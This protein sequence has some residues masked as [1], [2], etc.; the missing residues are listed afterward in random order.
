MLV[1]SNRENQVTL[2]RSTPMMAMTVVLTLVGWFASSP[3]SF[4]QS[5]KESE[6]K[7]AAD[8]VRVMSFNIRFGLA[9]DGN[10]SWPNRDRLV[11]DTINESYPDLL[12]V[13][14]AMPFQIQFL[15]ENLKDRSYVGSSR[16]ANP[17]GEQCGVFYRTSRFALLDQGQFWL[18]ETPN[19]KFT[20]S[21]DSSLPR[22]ATW[23]RL[24]DLKTSHQL[25][26]LNTHFD[27]RG[28]EARFQAARVIREFIESQ[29]QDLPVIVTGD[30]NC[31]WDS[32]PYRELLSSQR[33]TDTWLRQQKAR[34]D[35][36]G[37]FNGF[38][39][40]DDGA[41]IDWVLCSADFTV[42]DASIVKTSRDG[43]Y[44]SDHFPVTAVLK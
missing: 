31:G 43:Q 22:I 40:T 42:T 25:L 18:S 10:N 23:V 28:A 44:P 7:E 37:T 24:K 4:A 1:D 36:E 11:V 13:Q 20:K 14:E 27:H 19:K 41:R 38:K 35:R 33:L 26:F 17:E 6:S 29:P 39:G 5:E 9:K 21:W 15:K 32:R 2:V 8:S 3:S 30:F 12:G 16:D 34:P